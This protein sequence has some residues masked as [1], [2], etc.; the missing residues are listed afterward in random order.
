MSEVLGIGF[1]R[2][3]SIGLLKL[4]WNDGCYEGIV[5]LRGLI[6]EG[7][8]LRADPPACKTSSAFGSK[9]MDIR[10]IGAKKATSSL[11]SAAIGCAR[12]RKSRPPCSL[13]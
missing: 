13:A 6:A 5:D 9:A 7:E 4:V 10:S 12:W 1:R 2:G 8:I 11:I 3:R